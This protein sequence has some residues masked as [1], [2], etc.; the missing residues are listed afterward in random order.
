MAIDWQAILIAFGG[1]AALLLAF[2]WLM[3]TLISN[4]LSK[5]AD[6]FR[7][8]LQMAAVEHQVRYSKLHERRA[9]VIARLYRL[10]LEAADAAKTFAAN[11]NDKTLGNEQ[12]KQHVQLYRFF[13]INKIYLP[14][15]L[16][17][18][19]ENYERVLRHSVVFLKVYMSVEQPNPQMIEQQN[20]VL[21]EAWQAIE[22]DLPS[23]MRELEK[24][25]RKLLGV[26]LPHAKPV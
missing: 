5:D 22:T 19:L 1:Q 13:H 17:G 4:Q 26:E 6:A 3:K 11:P 7:S 18:L 25:F 24:E 12:W 16:C 14:S 20:K 2:A 15:T 9:V 8:S 10:L 23:I 21:R